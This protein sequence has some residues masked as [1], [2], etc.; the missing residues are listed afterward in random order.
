[1][2]DII[3]GAIIG[4]I[5]SGVAV[6]IAAIITADKLN[7]KITRKNKLIEQDFYGS[8]EKGF[9]K[10]K[11]DIFI[12][13]YIL[14]K[15]G[16][17]LKYHTPKDDVQIR[18]L[19]IDTTNENML[20]EFCKRYYP[21]MEEQKKEKIL[22]S[23]KTYDSTIVQLKNDNPNMNI[24]EKI[25][26]RSL[27]CVI[28]AIDII[29]PNKNSFIEVFYFVEGQ[30]MSKKRVALIAYRDTKL[31]DELREQIDFLWNEDTDNLIKTQ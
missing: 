14:H 1:M 16:D 27:N 2:S 20:N 13:G 22:S 30:R 25:T 7:L 4:A 21:K 29:K 17:S 23:R 18:L 24:V 8:W 9:K 31:F 28:F 15:V 6:I 19:S 10:A 5:I 11:N 26:K 12:S 3:I